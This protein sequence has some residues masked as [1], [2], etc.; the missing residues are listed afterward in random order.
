MTLIGSFATV[1]INIDSGGPNANKRQPKNSIKAMFVVLL[2]FSSFF[3][4]KIKSSMNNYYN[5][6]H[7]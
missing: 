1:R 4:I 3:L 6:D 7:P 5:D 2:L